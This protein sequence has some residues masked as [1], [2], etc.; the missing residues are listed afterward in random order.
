M[1]RAAKG[2]GRRWLSVAALTLGFLTPPIAIG[3]AGMRW[4]DRRQH[5]APP[6]RLAASTPLPAVPEH[7][8]GKR[9]VAVLLGADLT[10]I[11][12][13]LGPYEM[14]ARAGAFNVYTVASERQPTLLSGGLQI[15]PHLSLAE[16]DARLEG[17]QPPIV[18]VPMIP[19]IT[20][21]ANL[22]LVRWMQRQAAS[23]ALMHYHSDPGK[24]LTPSHPLA[25]RHARDPANS[26]WG[27]GSP[28]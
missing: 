8:P 27:P 24:A 4:L 18:V 26:N 16:L 23:G 6:P 14:F 7:D 20:S 19:N 1:A 25:H 11:T 15:L 10:E 22:P 21:D 17:Q 9:T 13:A 3:I 12:D 2:P 28:L 5:P